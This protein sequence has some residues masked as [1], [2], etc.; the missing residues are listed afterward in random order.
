MLPR[1]DLLFALMLALAS[2]SVLPARPVTTIVATQEVQATP[3]PVP[4]VAPTAD[5]SALPTAD[6]LAGWVLTSDEIKYINSFRFGMRYA[7][8]QAQKSLFDLVSQFREDP[9]VLS[10]NQ[11]R[12]EAV[13]MTNSL[14]YMSFNFSPKSP[15]ERFAPFV[16][17]LDEMLGHYTDAASLVQ[18]GIDE[19][20]GTKVE[21]AVREVAAATSLSVAIDTAFTALVGPPEN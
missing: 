14:A 4:T 20:D 3:V 2:C 11:W 16:S 5:P 10:N 8:P 1:I 17:K 19:M 12:K 6:E 13:D 21:A 15:S 18:G 9:S 7:M